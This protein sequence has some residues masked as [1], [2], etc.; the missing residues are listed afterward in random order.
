MATAYEGFENIIKNSEVVNFSTCLVCAPV[1][2]TD[3]AVGAGGTPI[4]VDVLAYDYDPNNNIK[5]STLAIAVQPNNGSGYVSNGKIV[6]LPNGSY[7]GRDTLT[8]QICD[9]TALCATGQVFFT[10]N[11]L[12]VSGNATAPDTNPAFKRTDKRGAMAFPSTLFEKMI[13]LAPEASAT[14]AI[15]L[16]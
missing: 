7:S 11:P 6:Y 3:S 1:A 13:S 14:C 15:T 16:V 8:Y 5:T 2:V 10:V 4:T 12:L 9:S